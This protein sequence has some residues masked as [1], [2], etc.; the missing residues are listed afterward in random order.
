L[1]V[2]FV[3]MDID[4]GAKDQ[5]AASAE[6]A[7]AIKRLLLELNE[8][9]IAAAAERLKRALARD[10][11]EH[12][13]REL[14]AGLSIDTLQPATRA[15]LGKGANSE[16]PEAVSL[17][18][19]SGMWYYDSATMSIRYR[20]NGHADQVLTNWL[21]QLVAATGAEQE[22]FAYLALKELAKPTAAGLCVSCHSIEK[23]D[24]GLATIHWRASDHSST[25]RPF[26][27]F[28]HGPHLLLRELADCTACHMID[29]KADTSKSYADWG[30]SDFVSEFQPMAKHQCATCHTA[31]AAGD[32]C[33]KCHH[34][35]IE[36]AE[37][38]GFG[39]QGS[40]SLRTLLKTRSG[41]KT[42][43]E[44][45]QAQF[46]PRTAQIEPVP[47]TA[48]LRPGGFETTSNH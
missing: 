23:S 1:G 47:A 31:K 40:V 20:P 8:K 14:F 46:A 24:E 4:A 38:S 33:Q 28:A 25:A 11:P 29:E 9:G 48:G 15:W 19:T 34:Y 35:H 26:T 22:S 17:P 44:G 3:F 45:G 39:V 2:D 30:A 6:L 43:S 42:A 12:E 21:T 13:L 18:S 10:V 32:A 16:P 41:F 7:T 5:L 37:G 36:M 27:K